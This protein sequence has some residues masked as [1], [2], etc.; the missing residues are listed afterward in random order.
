MPKNRNSVENRNPEI[1]DGY[2]K[3]RGR[4]C[5]VSNSGQKQRRRESE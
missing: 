5:G 1:L 4:G 3:I 2:K